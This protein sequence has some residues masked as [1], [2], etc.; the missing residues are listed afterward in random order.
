MGFK[1]NCFATAWT[2]KATNK[3]IDKFEKYAEVQLT[4]SKK[5]DNTYETDFSGKVRFVGKAFTAIKDIELAE[6]DRLKL[7]EVEVTNKYDKD[8]RTTYTNYVCWDFECV[9]EPKKSAPQQPE[10]VGEMTPL[11]D[12]FD[13]NLGGLP[14]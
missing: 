12:M 7:L 10:V 13:D 5:K 6:K 4:T 1:N 3:V 9:N 14:F 8:R 11:D 2:N